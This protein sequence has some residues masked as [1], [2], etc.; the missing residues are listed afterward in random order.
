VPGV[1]SAG[2]GAGG[3]S[4]TNWN[5]ILRTAGLLAGLGGA[6]LGAA[7]IGQYL[8]NG[9]QQTSAGNLNVNESVMPGAMTPEQTALQSSLL[10]SATGQLGTGAALA[11]A[12]ANLIG[13][14]SGSA[15]Q[16]DPYLQALLSQ[17]AYG[18]AQ[19]QLPA[20][21]P[22]LW[23]ALDQVYSGRAMD[24]DRMLGNYASNIR[25]QMNAKGWEGNFGQLMRQGPGQQLM[26]P[27]LAE[28][29][30]QRGQL[31][32]QEAGQAINL[33]TTLP[34]TAMNLGGGALNQGLAANQNLQGIAGLYNAPIQ[35]GNQ[36]GLGI[37][38]A[39]NA[40][41]ARGQVRTF[42][43]ASQNVGAQPTLTGAFNQALP[44]L[45]GLGGLLDQWGRMQTQSGGNGGATP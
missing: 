6:G 31:A 8:A 42:N 1:G 33:A 15:P 18:M 45:G 5:D 11:P 25:D 32:G 27:A 17:N 10:S 23:D 12:Q 4:G 36:F 39:M 7:G 29:V 24:I 19:G 20:L 43:Q 37:Y 26:A 41:G 13:G 2:G 14:I 35:L 38:N 34:T 21:S 28:A 30:R 3:G 16:A 22:E 9:P 44:V 40:P